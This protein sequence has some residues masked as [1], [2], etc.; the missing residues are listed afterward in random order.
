MLEILLVGVLGLPLAVSLWLILNE[1]GPP[2]YTRWVVSLAA[3]ATALC[4]LGLLSFAGQ[5]PPLTLTWL[6]AAGPM[7][8]S[9]GITGLYVLTATAAAAA[10]VFALMAEPLDTRM[11]ALTLVALAAGNLA[12]LAGHFLLRYVALEVVGLCIAAAPLLDPVARQRLR[13][14]GWVYLVLRLGDAALL[15]ATL[16]LGA[17]AGTFE[18]T[19]ALAAVA[20]LPPNVQT[21]ISIGFLLAVAVKVGL[22]PFHA[23]IESGMRLTRSTYTW[24]YATLMPNLGLYLL[25]RVAPLAGGLPALRALLLIAGGLTGVALLLTLLR[26][27]DPRRLPARLGILLTTVVWGLALGW[28]AEVAW[29]GL[30][31]LTLVRLPFYLRLPATLPS[32]KAS[33]GW[34]KPRY[35]VQHLAEQ[36]H[37]GVEIGLLERGLTALGQGLPAWAETLYQR[38]EQQSLEGLLRGIV[39][40]TLQGS[41]QL[42]R[43]HTGRLRANLWWI[44]LCLA[45]AIS[46]AVFA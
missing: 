18:I 4:A 25:Y 7:Q 26:Y 31:A 24:L 10:V 38:V 6:P 32:E 33:P 20:T 11:G 12:F 39:R 29:W 17:R 37:S 13:H 40:R 9:L 2:R 41:R 22:W 3:G 45:L 16:L 1:S 30:V 14:A 42:R 8:L 34:L 43:L 36:L 15:T 44:V 46:W 35:R 5:I 23:W 21:W 27:P 28:R 19:P